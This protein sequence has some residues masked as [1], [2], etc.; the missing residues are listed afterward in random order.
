MR[1]QWLVRVRPSPLEIDIDQI[2]DQTAIA[3]ATTTDTAPEFVADGLLRTLHTASS[4]D[5]FG[6]DEIQSDDLATALAARKAAADMLVKAR[7]ARFSDDTH[8]EIA[9]TNAGRY[10]ALH[11]GYL[12][13]LK[14]DAAATINGGGG[15]RQRNPEMEALRSEYMKLRLNTFWWSFGLSVAGFVMSILSVIIAVFYGDRLIR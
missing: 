6:S 7:L 8:T 13:Y 12:A 15:G 3:P 14:D 11:G 4:A 2:V 9:I 10:W 5:V 1:R